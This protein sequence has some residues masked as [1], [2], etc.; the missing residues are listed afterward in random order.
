LAD[1][2]LSYAIVGPKGHYTFY[3]DGTVVVENDYVAQ[4]AYQTAQR[5]PAELLEALRARSCRCESAGKP[6]HGMDA[7]LGWRLSW[8]HAT[9]STWCTEAQTPCVA[10]FV[11]RLGVWL[12]KQ[13]EYWPW[14]I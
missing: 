11:H 8:E 4:V 1:L 13:C 6:H 9:S 5:L 7:G 3:D 10:R 14:E 12:K 2:W